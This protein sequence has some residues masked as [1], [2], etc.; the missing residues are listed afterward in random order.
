[1]ATNNAVL[2]WDTTDA[3]ATA[4]GFAYTL[5]DAAGQAVALAGVTC[6]AV[7]GVTVCQ[8]PITVP[9][10]GPHSYVLSAS[11]PLGAASSAPLVGTAPAVP[12]QLA[13]QITVTV[14]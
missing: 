4:Q 5:K 14:S 10:A 6:Q 12:T 7:G 3:P 8:A 2:V 9:A 1:M 11:S 13:V